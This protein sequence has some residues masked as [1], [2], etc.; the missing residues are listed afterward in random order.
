MVGDV[1][2]DGV[3]S[4]WVLS[5]RLSG[6][7]GWALKIVRE[8]ILLLLLITLLSISPVILV[9]E[10]IWMV[11]ILYLVLLLLRC[12]P[13]IWTHLFDALDVLLLSGDG[14]GGVGHGDLQLGSPDGGGVVGAFQLLLHLVPSL[15]F[16]AF[17]ARGG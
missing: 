12:L 14:D 2:G 16:L 17:G 4:S 3:G 15:H 1:I 6:I 7:L 13:D 9:W 10:G 8:S 5:G 11:L